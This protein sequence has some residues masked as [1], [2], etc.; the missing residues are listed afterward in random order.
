[1]RSRRLVPRG[2][3]HGKVALDN[4]A[5]YLSIMYIGNSTNF[6]RHH[7][8]RDAV[9]R[10]R[11]ILRRRWPDVAFVSHAVQSDSFAATATSDAKVRPASPPRPR[12][13]ASAR[14]RT[15]HARQAG[16]G[17]GGARFARAPNSNPKLGRSDAPQLDYA[18][19]SLILSYVLYFENLYSTSR[20]KILSLTK[21]KHF[22]RGL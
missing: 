12:V 21:T 2:R 13:G 10:D 3:W 19:L 17:R 22:F 20:Y 7:R 14:R 5:S 16:I 15:A 1:M 18:R 11:P 9:A 4:D 6:T 8:H